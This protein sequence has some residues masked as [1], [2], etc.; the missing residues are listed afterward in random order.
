M[1]EQGFWGIFTMKNCNWGWRDC[2]NTFKFEQMATTLQTFS[3]WPFA[4]NDWILLLKVQ[5][6]S[7]V[8]VIAWHQIGNKTI[9]WSSAGPVHWCSGSLGLSE[10]RSHIVWRKPT[11]CTFDDCNGSNYFKC[12]MTATWPLMAVNN[13]DF[14]LD[15]SDCDPINLQYKHPAVWPAWRKI[16]K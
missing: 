14:N 8:Q 15:G 13:R 2:F 9:A 5:L 7:L 11:T 10:L 1:G 6:T 12:E 4:L 16:L 3:Y